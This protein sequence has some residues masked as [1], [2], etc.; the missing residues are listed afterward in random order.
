[1]LL[2][3]LKKNKINNI[4]FII[5]IANLNNLNTTELS[6]KFF[7]LRVKNIQIEFQILLYS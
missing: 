2:S 7:Y 5:Q 4:Q 3:C 1:M 6:R